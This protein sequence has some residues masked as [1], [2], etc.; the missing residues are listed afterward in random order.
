MTKSSDV[1]KPKVT[2]TERD[3]ALA[4]ERIKNEL[5]K[6]R[7]LIERQKRNNRIIV[8][9][10][11]V[12]CLAIGGYVLFVVRQPAVI[13]G[14]ITSKAQFPI[15]Y[16]VPSKKVMIEGSSFKYDKS[17]GQVSFIVNFAKADITFAEQS[18]PESFSA[19]PNFYSAF[20]Q[21]LNG[22]DTFSGEDGRVDLTIPSETHDQTAVMNAQGTLLFAST[23]SQL[24][25]SNWK[26]LFYSLNNTTP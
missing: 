1:L 17:L 2:K 13:P 21:K 10:L 7:L 3:A 8:G 15:F 12:V 23:P 16:P 5:L 19:D 11:I 26:L 14:S 9:L 6:R 22:Y 24:S 4:K 18:S 20:V 25:E